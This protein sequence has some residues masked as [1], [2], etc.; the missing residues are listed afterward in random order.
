MYLTK[1]FFLLFAA[2]AALFLAAFPLP[3]LFPVAETALVAAVG[4][5]F[6]D[7]AQLFFRKL[8]LTASRTVAPVLSLSDPN[9]V[10]ISLKNNSGQKL[11]LTVVDE[12]PAQ[13]QRRDFAEHTTLLPG[14]AQ[15]LDFELLPLERGEYNFGNVLV[16]AATQ[17][18]LIERRLRLATPETVAVY[19]SIIQM[20]R[21]ELLALRQTAHQTGVKKMRRLGHS[22]EFEQIKNYV[23]GDDYRSLNWKATGRR[24]DLMVNQYEDERS[25]QVWCILDKSR[26]MLMPF[27]GLTLLDYSINSALAISNIVLKKQD[28][29]GLLSFSNVIGTTLKPER[30][31][32]QL[33]RILESLYR[34]RER[35]VEANFDLL[36]QAVRRLVGVRSLLL[37]FT[38]FESRF[39]LERALPQ[40]RRLAKSHLLVV[41]FFENTEVAALAE[42][43][44]RTVAGQ[45]RQKLAQQFLVEK[46]EMA[47]QLRR[48]GIQT[49][50]TRPEN[51]TVNTLNKY[52]ELK[53]R[54]VV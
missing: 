15:T 48:F 27:G 12:L 13:F 18:G 22:Y 47:A 10:R 25:Q 44:P 39:A 37:L 4:A 30:S 43:E 3:W 21:Y 20:K 17:I 14:A 26:P 41:I 28:K 51:L 23:D 42:Q 35:P 9:R 32:A 11:H 19:P 45:I 1:R 46:R 31:P 24:G 34:E 2:V 50:L 16:F 5:V 7:I 52:L 49:V 36:F 40:L 53:A 6:A 29:A 54:G 8:N 38:N 33:H